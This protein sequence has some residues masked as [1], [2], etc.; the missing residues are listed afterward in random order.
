MSSI[1]QLKLRIK[2]LE[3]QLENERQ[4]REPVQHAREKIAQM[5]S[6]VV[7][8]NPYRYDVVTVCK[9]RPNIFLHYILSCIILKKKIEI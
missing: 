2:Q 1:E 9:H 3:N 5:S 7:D 8:S 6:E 4:K